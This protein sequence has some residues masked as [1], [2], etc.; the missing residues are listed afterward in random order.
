MMKRAF[1]FFVMIIVALLVAMS[2]T[3]PD[4]REHYAVLRGVALQAADRHLSNSQAA[5]YVSVSAALAMDAVD[6]FLRQNFEV[7]DY[8]FVTVGTMRY[9]GMQVPVSVGVLGKVHILVDEDKLN[10]IFK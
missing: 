10:H 3:K 2:V 4:E 9:R 8:M 7:N 5:D 6:P 1:V